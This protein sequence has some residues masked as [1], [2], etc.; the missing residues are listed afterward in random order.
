MIF[1]ILTFLLYLAVLTFAG[2]RAF[3]TQDAI[4]QFVSVLLAAAGILVLL[5]CV[6]T[7]VFSICSR[8]RFCAK[9][10][11]WA[12][13]ND[14]EY[15]S[16]H[17]PMLSFFKAYEGADIILKTAKKH[18]CIKFFPFFTKKSILHIIDENGAFF[19]KQW[20]LFFTAHRYAAGSVGVGRPLQEEMMQHKK[21]VALIF[22]EAPGEKIIIISPTCYKASCVVDNHVETIDNNYTWKNEI[23]FW[24][25]KS[26][27][28]FLDQ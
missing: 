6:W 15:V 9:L 7:W 26:F 5:K 1:A 10:K 11:H 13:N 25:Q 4:W 19:S 14:A 8:L 2:W 12:E 16:V 23:A 27:F 3:L 24:Y 28:K 17:S 21:R 20:A 22:D 18:Y